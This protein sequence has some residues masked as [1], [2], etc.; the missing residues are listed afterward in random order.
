MKKTDIAYAAGFF[1]GE[2]SIVMSLLKGQYLRLEVTCSQNTIT[3]LNLFK[4]M[5][6]GGVYGNDKCYQWK[7]FGKK[8]VDFLHVVLP[9][10]VVKNAEAQEAIACWSN[11]GDREFVAQVIRLKRQRNEERYRYHNPT[12]TRYGVRPSVEEDRI[13]ATSCDGRTDEHD[14]SCTGDDL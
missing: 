9:Y 1:D 2:G 5:F 11:R 3:V 10:L 4:R 8:G 13:D 12:G 7:V 14:A 6:G